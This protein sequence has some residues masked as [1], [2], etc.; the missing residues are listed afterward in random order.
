MAAPA[1][2][3][4]STTVNGYSEDKTEDIS[5]YDPSLI[6]DLDLST[7]PA[8]FSPA[9][10]I[11]SPGDSLLVRPLNIADY[12]RGFLQLLAHLTSVGDVS[13]EEWEERFHN[14]KNCRNTYFVTV[15][16]D[17]DTYQ[18]LANYCDENHF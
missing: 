9:L 14:M 11:A 15:I 18:V 6:S 13:R 8:T 2:V 3:N 7:S 1:T 5:L 16:E 10:S 12:D 17:T 4:G